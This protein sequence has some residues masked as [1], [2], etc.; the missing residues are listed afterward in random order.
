M[1]KVIISL[2]ASSSVETKES[3]KAAIAKLQEKFDKAMAVQQAK[4]K[5]LNAAHRAANP[6]AVFKDGWYLGQQLAESPKAAAKELSRSRTDKEKSRKV[7]V[8]EDGKRKAVIKYNNP[9]IGSRAPRG[10]CWTSAGM[11]EKY[12][13]VFKGMMIKG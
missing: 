9:G 1:S 4:L 12:S 11:K 6:P 5:A 3:I 8:V 2:S 13:K 7:I 10:L